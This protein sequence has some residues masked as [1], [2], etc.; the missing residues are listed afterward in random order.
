MR[1]S[2]FSI[3]PAFALERSFRKQRRA[4]LGARQAVR[5]RASLTAALY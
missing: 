5:P 2:L 4:P 1:R 3:S